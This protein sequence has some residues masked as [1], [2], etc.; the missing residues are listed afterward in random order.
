MQPDKKVYKLPKSPTCSVMVALGSRTYSCT[1]VLRTKA[2][3]PVPP[4]MHSNAP[5]NPPNGSLHVQRISSFSPAHLLHTF[6]GLLPVHRTQWQCWR[7]AR[8]QVWLTD[9]VK[10]LH[11]TPHKI[12]HFGDCSPPYHSE[13]PT[14]RGDLIGATEN[15]DLMLEYNGILGLIL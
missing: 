15:A 1:V 6:V 11:P 4:A 14:W 3:S 10:V 13:G 9:W 12:D 5:A 2:T 8:M 7:I